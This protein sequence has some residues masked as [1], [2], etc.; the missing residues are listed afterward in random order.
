MGSWPHALIS[1]C[2]PA[3]SYRTQLLDF[4]ICY[5]NNFS[6]RTCLPVAPGGPVGPAAPVA[7]GPPAV[8][9]AP[10][11][12]S[13]PGAPWAPAFPGPPASPGSPVAPCGEKTA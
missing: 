5:H 10:W 9:V 6:I 11:L 13:G 1:I 4:S 3:N 2:L 7:P 12:P 8:P